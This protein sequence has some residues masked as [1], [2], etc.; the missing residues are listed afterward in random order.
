MKPVEIQGRVVRASA[1]RWH[2]N[3]DTYLRRFSIKKERASV[4]IDDDETSE[5]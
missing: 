3:P 1:P 2:N 4:R 5:P